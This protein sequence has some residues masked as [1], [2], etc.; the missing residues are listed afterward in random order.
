[1]SCERLANVLHIVKAIEMILLI[2]L[3]LFGSLRVSDALAQK[4]WNVAFTFHVDAIGLTMKTKAGFH[5]A[6][7]TILHLTSW[8]SIVAFGLPQ[9]Q[10]GASKLA[11]FRTTFDLFLWDFLFGPTRSGLH[12]LKKFAYPGQFLQL[13][14]SLV[15]ITTD[16]VKFWING[17]P[18]GST[19]LW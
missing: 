7:S 9:I 6:F 2:L 3:I 18:S 4:I 19:R 16:L 8:P 13:R 15:S 1:M 11:L 14:F 12:P 10:S 17:S 5:K